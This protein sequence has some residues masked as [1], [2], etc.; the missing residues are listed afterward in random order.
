[1][2]QRM[3]IMHKN[4]SGLNWLDWLNIF[5]RLPWQYRKET[6]EFLVPKTTFIFTS[7]FINGFPFP[8]SF[9]SW[10]APS[11]SPL[12]LEFCQTN[13]KKEGEEINIRI[14]C[15]SFAGQHEMLREDTNIPTLFL[16]FFTGISLFLL[17]Q[18][19]IEWHH[20]SCKITLQKHFVKHRTVFIIDVSVPFLSFVQLDIVLYTI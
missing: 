20:F 14:A 2:F 7:W 8:T 1:M 4:V 11:R 19:S 17:C 5:F 12:V 3:N 15:I 10:K 18:Y 16:I 9:F 6:I 13:I